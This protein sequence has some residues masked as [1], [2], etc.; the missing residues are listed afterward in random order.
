MG[1]GI[2]WKE[3]DYLKFLKGLK[4]FLNI[5]TNNKKIAASMGEDY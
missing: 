4:Y 1:T 5:P 3:E 2:P